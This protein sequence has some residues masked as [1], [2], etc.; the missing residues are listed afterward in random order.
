[1]KPLL[2]VVGSVSLALGVIGV[3]L[4][5]MPTTPFLLLAAYCYARSSERMHRWLLTH[6]RLGCYVEGF[7]YGGGVPRRAKRAALLTLWPAIAVS[8]TIVFLTASSRAVA[9]GAPAAMVATA[10]IV[11]VYIVTRPTASDR[12]GSL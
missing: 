12:S 7:L 2:L 3:F 10:A 6:R 5:V 1:M 8:C 11:S 4:P 9:I